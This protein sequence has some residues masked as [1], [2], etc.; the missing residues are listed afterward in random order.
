MLNI[1]KTKYLVFGPPNATRRSYQLKITLSNVDVVRISRHENEKSIRFLGLLLDEHITWNDHIAQVTNKIKKGI[2]VLN[3][4]KN[5]L[6][7]DILR[8]V[9]FSLIHSHVTYGLS[10][11]GNSSNIKKI[12]LLQKAALRI[13]SKAK[14]RSHTN[15]LFLKNRILKLPDIY[16]EQILNFMHE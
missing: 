15:S 10:V 9:Y 4:L 8:T 11:W 1:K 16:E 7:Q 12:H 5:F 14:F 13:I 2:Y 6:P 3:Q